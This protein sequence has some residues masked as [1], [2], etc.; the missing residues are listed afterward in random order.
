M[1]TAP[2][3]QGALTAGHTPPTPRREPR[4]GVELRR[5]MRD[6]SVLVI[7]MLDDSAIGAGFEVRLRKDGELIVG[8][9]CESEGLARY[10]AEAFAQD[11]LRA[12]WQANV[13]GINTVETHRDTDAS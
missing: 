10:V 8:R 7:E 1:S 5:L 9:R 6:S 3:D 13:D 4:R 12:G 2:R 11:H